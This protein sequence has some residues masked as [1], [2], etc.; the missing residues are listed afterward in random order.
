MQPESMLIFMGCAV[1]GC[2][3]DV[4]GLCCHE[5]ILMSLASAATKGSDGVHGP[6][7]VKSSVDVHLWP[8]LP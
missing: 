1:S 4:S 2:H 6:C 5:V 3:V 7:S 8:V